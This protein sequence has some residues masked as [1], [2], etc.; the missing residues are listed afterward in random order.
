MLQILFLTRI[1]HDKHWFSSEKWYL[2]SFLGSNSILVFIKLF[3]LK[4]HELMKVLGYWDVGIWVQ[5]SF[6][7]NKMIVSLMFG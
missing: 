1:W 3:Y 6:I 2:I 4:F 5:C 7:Q